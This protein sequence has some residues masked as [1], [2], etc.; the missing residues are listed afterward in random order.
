MWY[1]RGALVLYYCIAQACG[2]WRRQ[3][4]VLGGPSVGM[5]VARLGRPTAGTRAGRAHDSGRMER[6]PRW[7]RGADCEALEIMKMHAACMS[8]PMLLIGLSWK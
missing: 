7:Q 5:G 8:F 2:G 4:R 3:I 1:R 6:A